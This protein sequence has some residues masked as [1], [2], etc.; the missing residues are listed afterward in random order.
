MSD[1]RWRNAANQVITKVVSD[2]PGLPEHELR[3]K[4]SEAYPFGMRKFHP[5]K[6]WLSAIND[7]FDP[8]PARKARTVAANEGQLLFNI[9]EADA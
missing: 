8:R 6:I 2:N 4:L 1:S 7:Y 5:Y 9:K 3:K